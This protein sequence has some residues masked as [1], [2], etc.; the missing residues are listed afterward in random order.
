VQATK[1][2]FAINLK[3]ATALGV[4]VPPKLLAIAGKVIE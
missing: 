4:T 1:L 3:P 2:D